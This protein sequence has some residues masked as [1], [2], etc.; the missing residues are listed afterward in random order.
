LIATHYVTGTNLCGRLHEKLYVLILRYLLS[1][2]KV[3]FMACVHVYAFAE[4]IC[5]TRGLIFT[6]SFNMAVEFDV[7]RS[8]FIRS[9]RFFKVIISVAEKVSQSRASF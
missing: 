9:L 3:N 1:I 7:P 2:F 8:Y 5:A 4:I 6:S